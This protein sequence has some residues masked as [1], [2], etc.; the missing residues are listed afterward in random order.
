MPPF[1]SRYGSPGELWVL[2][3][4]LVEADAVA[5]CPARSVDPGRMA[6][7]ELVAEMAAAH[8][9][10]AGGTCRACGVMLPCPAFTA[11][12]ALALEHVIVATSVIADRWCGAPRRGVSDGRSLEHED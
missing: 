12:G 11:A 4:A 2:A 3:A 7:G 10:D 6:I 5:V 9:A 8:G 1:A